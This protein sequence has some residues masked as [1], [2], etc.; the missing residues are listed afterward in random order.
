MSLEQAQAH[1]AK[2]GFATGATLTVAPSPKIPKPRLNKT[3]SEYARMLEA[4]QRRGDILEYRF[5][6]VTLA[7]GADPATGKPMKYTPDFWVIESAFRQNAYIGDIRIIEVKG[8]HIFDRDIVRFKGCRAEW[9]RFR[10]EMHQKKQG[11]W[12]RIL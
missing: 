10:F 7:W 4:Q 9:P 2:H 5:E 11:E 12:R 6:G 1:Q 3:E 8:A